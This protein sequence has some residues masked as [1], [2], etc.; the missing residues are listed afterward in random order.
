MLL[1]EGELAY[2]H[3]TYSV[4]EAEYRLRFSCEV[5]VHHSGQ[6]EFR[7]QYGCVLT[8]LGPVAESV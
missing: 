3:K 8:S 6:C 7:C 1:E 2:S 5:S 4:L